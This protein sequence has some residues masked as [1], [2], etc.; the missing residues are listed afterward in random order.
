MP[1]KFS[2]GNPDRGCRSIFFTALFGLLCAGNTYAEKDP[3]LHLLEAEAGDT[4]ALQIDHTQSDAD[5]E[6]RNRHKVPD[7]LGFPEFEQA[8]QNN[9]AGTN[10][11]YSSLSLLQREQ[12]YTHYRSNR[13]V[14]VLRQKFPGLQV[15]P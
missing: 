11:L 9:Y 7:R 1:A 2:T 15:T 13:S 12:V 3:Y 10:A 6:S 5:N 4:D 14:A 8:L